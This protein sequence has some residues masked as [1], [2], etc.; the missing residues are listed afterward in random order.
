[1]S[2]STNLL[3]IGLLPDSPGIPV[4]P[5]ANDALVKDAL[6]VVWD[7]QRARA[8]P[9]GGTCPPYSLDTCHQVGRPGLAAAHQV[10]KKPAPAYR[11]DRISRDAF[12]QALVHSLKA[13]GRPGEA[14]AVGAC[15]Q[16]F[17]TGK[18]Q[19]CGAYPAFPTSCKHRLCADCA[20]RR[21][22]LLISEHESLLKALRYPKMLTLTF[23][24]IEHLDRAFIR[25]ARKCFTRLRHRKIFAGCWG[26]IYSFE[27]T[28]TKGKGWHLHLHAVLGS[29]YIPEAALSREWE[30]ITGAWDV[31]ISAIK[32]DDK[33][34]A[35]QE[36]V[37]YPAKAATFL[38]NPSLVNEFLNATEGVS[39][40]YGFGA[41]YRVKTKGHSDKPLVC[42]VCGGT[43]ITW[44]G[45]VDRSAVERAK[46]G[47]VWKGPARSP[48]GGVL[49]DE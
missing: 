38:D 18:C 36:V 2:Q 37:K 43:H 31:W 4:S 20:A 35:V 32:G 28:Y 26:G 40:A 13:C 16:Q 6:A 42:P 41:M 19:D 46:D 1:M 11:E 9:P 22:A 39:L 47:Y 34:S 29:K 44:L 7:A 45:L 27:A 10:G 23:L 48:P 49:R 25:W 3:S 21:G 17:K 33:W 8:F 30:K 5:P 15:G 12:R 14:E 24:P